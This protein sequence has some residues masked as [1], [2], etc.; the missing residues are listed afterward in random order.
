MG[1]AALRGVGG[2]SWLLEDWIGAY[3][4]FEVEPEEIL[5]LGN[6]VVFACRPGGPSGW[7]QRSRPAALRERSHAGRTA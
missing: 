3:E 4:E 5:D 2:D 7:Q 1:M 6:G